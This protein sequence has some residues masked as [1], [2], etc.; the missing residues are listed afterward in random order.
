MPEPH[1]NPPRQIA[2][3]TFFLSD[4]LTVGVLGGGGVC[5]SAG[6]GGSGFEGGWAP[7]CDQSPVE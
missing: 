7:H 4:S 3:A 1:P 5:G 6:A 2:A